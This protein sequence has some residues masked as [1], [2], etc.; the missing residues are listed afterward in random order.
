[1]KVARLE[2]TVV[3]VPY[4][5]RE[6]SAIVARDGV[7]DVLVHVD[8]DDGLVG[9]GEPRSGGD[10]GSVESRCGRW[11]RSLSAGAP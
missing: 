11:S 9:W 8:M 7:M 3:S 10:A 5:D 6:T 4:S 2:T 1:V